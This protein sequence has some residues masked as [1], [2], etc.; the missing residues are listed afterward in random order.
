MTEL[1][2]ET[3][4]FRTILELGIKLDIADESKEITVCLINT[5][6]ESESPA[7]W[8]L[9]PCQ[10]AA[11]ICLP[12]EKGANPTLCLPHFEKFR[13][14]NLKPFNLHCALLFVSTIS[15]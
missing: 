3:Q 8:R 7:F 6:N 12:L 15:L 13:M 4:Q 2:D 14:L 10:Y 11:L 1:V 5:G 9:K